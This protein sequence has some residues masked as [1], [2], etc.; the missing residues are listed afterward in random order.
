M[1]LNF[2]PTLRLR[3]K[4]IVL[5]ASLLT[6][7]LCRATTA[8]PAPFIRL[9]ELEIDQSQLAAFQAAAH[10]HAEAALRLEPGLLALHAA[11]EKDQP[12]RIRVLEIY[13]DA[14][15]YRSHLQT[16]HFLQ[17]SE[18]IRPMV[19]TRQLLDAV[20]VR[21]GSKPAL[22]PQPHVRV[23]ELAIDPAQLQAYKDAVTEEID[24]SIRLEPGVLSIYAVALKDQPTQLRFLEIYADEA[25]YRLHIASPHFKKY[26][27]IT[28]PMIT[29]RRLLEA[30]PV[31]LGLPSR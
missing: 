26:V 23:A 2:T 14:Q 8:Q 9:A 25:A 21:L 31:L 1:P 24:A 13:A 27:A 16:P 11:A 19:R 4:R 28:Q 18:A 7:L 17:F 12:G 30:E 29:S 22:Q 10:T 3:W 6:L 20:P 5:G 15:A